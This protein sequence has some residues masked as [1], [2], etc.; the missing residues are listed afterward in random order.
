MRHLSV[1]LTSRGVDFD[2]N[3][4]RILCLPH[5]LNTCAKHVTENYK[6]ADVSAFARQVW[7]DDLGRQID[8][9]AYVEG[10]KHDP[11]KR[12]RNIVRSLRAS[13][14]RRN[15]FCSTIKNGNDMEVWLDADGE[16]A[17]ITE[18][19]LVL[20]VKSRWDSVYIMINRLREMQLVSNRV[21]YIKWD[22]LTRRI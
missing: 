11:I 7:V 21:I 22:Y 8:Q 5:L 13:H 9:K 14:L 15:A 20:D 10:L 3:E 18:K 1:L 2:A 17:D 4:R 6:S 16:H 19:Q 12:G